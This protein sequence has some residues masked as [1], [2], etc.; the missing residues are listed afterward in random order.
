MD[1][2]L[3]I[4]NDSYIIPKYHEVE[5]LMREALAYWNNFGDHQPLNLKIEKVQNGTET[6]GIKVEDGI[7]TKDK[8][9]GNS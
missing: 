3:I 1:F 9:P 5:R 7:F 2:K 4:N 6:I 8:G